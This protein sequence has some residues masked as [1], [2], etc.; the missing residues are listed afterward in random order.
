MTKPLQ[1]LSSDLDAVCAAWSEAFGGADSSLVGRAFCEAE[2]DEVSV[3]ESMSDGDLVAVTDAVAQLVRDGQALLARAAA[4][5]ARRSPAEL[6][7]EGLAKKRGFLNPVHLVAASTGGR[8]SEAAKLIAVGTGTAPRRALTG[9]QLPPAHPH[10]AA[11][12]A[13]G[14]IG[15]DAADAITGMLRRVA[16]G[17]DAGQAEAMEK[18]LAERAAGLPFDLLLRVIREAEARLDQDGVAPR[19]E[20]L[21]ADR[22][23]TIRQDTNGM[24]RLTARLDPETAAPVKAAIEAI[25]TRDIRAARP[26][27][28]SSGDT[29]HDDADGPVIADMR[30]VPQ[31][32][33]DALAMIARHVLGCNQVPA[34][35]STTVV[36]RMNLDTL[37]D[38]VGHGRIDGLDHPVSAGTLRR[39]A[40]TAG[41]IPA[42]LGTDSVPLDLGR[43]AR[44]FTAAQR[45]AL[46]ER[47]GGC[48]CCGLAVAYTEAHH[49][50]WWKRDTGPT[51][52]DNGVLLCPPCHARIH[53]DDWDIRIT[54]GQV[55]FIPPPQIDASRTP[56]LGG[57]ARFELPDVLAAA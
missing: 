39:M 20:E 53:Q 33:A 1:H 29:P 48:S 5:V 16:P 22:S 35:A 19:E 27:G 51:D 2:A 21:R 17:A 43:T 14:A 38:G 24:V 12:L 31:M 50:L 36:V 49:I 47:D 32:Q 42:V 23:L 7:R 6:G 55:W 45:I 28:D 10:V 41:I 11:A 4:E 44:T 18:V 13:S 37:V 57:R 3:V 9:E 56:R 46:S 26:G 54:N 52:L 15:L 40:A 30:S 34:T 8:A 25:V